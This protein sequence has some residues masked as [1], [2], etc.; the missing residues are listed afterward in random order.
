[1]TQSENGS[2]SGGA[3]IVNS[4][5]AGNGRH[6]HPRFKNRDRGRGQQHK[7]STQE[8]S[9][10]R[11]NELDLRK[12]PVLLEHVSVNVPITAGKRY[13][14]VSALL[15]KKEVKFLQKEIP[16]TAN[17]EN[18]G[19]MKVRDDGQQLRIGWMTWEEVLQVISKM[20]RVST[21]LYINFQKGSGEGAD[22]VPEMFKVVTTKNSEMA[23]TKMSQTDFTKWVGSR[24]AR[25]AVSAW[26]NPNED[27]SRSINL[28]VRP[29]TVDWTKL[30]HYKVE[31]V[32]R[33]R[34]GDTLPHVTYIG[35]AD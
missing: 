25:V 20:G 28:V 35:P 12:E 13:Y 31:L 15:G 3:T 17:R 23:G 4:S 27:G 8:Q 24:E 33:E 19:G 10:D 6:D 2:R 16:E 11:L 18:S 34:A 32:C 14:D 29:L 21:R 9:D 26:L 22:Q 30:R 1:M 5:G 7:P